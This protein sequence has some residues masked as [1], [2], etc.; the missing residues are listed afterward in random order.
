MIA[1]AIASAYSSSAKWPPSKITYLG[2]RHSLLH[3]FRGR[4][5]EERVISPPDDERLRLPVLQI[6]V[7]FRVV[8]EVRRE[9]HEQPRHEDPIRLD[10]ERIGVDRPIVRIQGV[11]L[12]RALL[13]EKKVA[14]HRGKLLGLGQLL[15]GF[16]AAEPLVDFQAF[17]VPTLH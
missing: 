14:F 5:H 6:G 16:R 1:S 10:R 9:V 11:G 7:P 15:W 4:R 2:R 3:E 8:L 13:V 12:A 17:R